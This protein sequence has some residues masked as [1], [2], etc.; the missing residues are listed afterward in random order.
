V[1]VHKKTFQYGPHAVTLETGEVARQ[2]DGAVLVAM[3]D[4]IVVC[5]G[6]RAQGSAT[7]ARTSSR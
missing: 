5:H 7:P 1:N 6:R 3:G 2:A 4:T